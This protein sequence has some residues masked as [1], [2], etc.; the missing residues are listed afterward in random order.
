MQCSTI[1]VLGVFFKLAFVDS[2]DLDRKDTCKR[3]G[4]SIGSQENNVFAVG[5][6]H[7]AGTVH[8]CLKIFKCRI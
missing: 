1:L 4:S 2:C 7:D 5:H 8:I 3:G 6:G